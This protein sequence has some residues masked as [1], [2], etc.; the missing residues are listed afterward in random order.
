MPGEAVLR[1]EKTRTSPAQPP[2]E[3]MATPAWL[4]EAVCEEAQGFLTLSLLD[5]PNQCE[6]MLNRH[7]LNGHLNHLKLNSFMI[8]MGILL[9]Y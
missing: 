3:S 9:V 7:L 8:L 4:C 2:G 5:K 1:G 6:Q